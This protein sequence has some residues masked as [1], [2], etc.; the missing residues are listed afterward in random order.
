MHYL[1]CDGLA[2]SE[3]N[4][5]VPSGAANDG[6]KIKQE[7]VDGKRAHQYLCGGEALSNGD[8]VIPNITANIEDAG[9]E[10]GEISQPNDLNEEGEKKPKKITLAALQLTMPSKR[11]ANDSKD[12]PFAP[13]GKARKVKKQ[14][15]P[16]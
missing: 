10:E 12:R 11:K 1:L 8:I 14:I 3:C 5:D 16:G 6:H 2:P 13:P 7:S 9:L 15:I 4:T